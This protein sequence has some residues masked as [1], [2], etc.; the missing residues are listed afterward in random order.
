MLS[1]PPCGSDGGG[2]SKV[3]SLVQDQKEQD[4]STVT[5]ASV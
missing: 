5:Q 3:R 1:A 4:R 2:S